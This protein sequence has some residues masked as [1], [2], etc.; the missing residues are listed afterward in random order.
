METIIGDD[1]SKTLFVCSVTGF[2]M[3]IMGPYASEWFVSSL[4][5]FTFTFICIL[6]K[7][8]VFPKSQTTWL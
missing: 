8:Y 5:L 3:L 4:H 7:H 1:N 6:V 2:S